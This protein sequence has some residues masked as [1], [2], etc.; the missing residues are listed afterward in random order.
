MRN[1]RFNITV[2]H[3]FSSISAFGAEINSYITTSR[4]NVHETIQINPFNF[5]NFK[6]YNYI[7][8]FF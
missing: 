1:A 7:L 2:P 3:L 4:F 6:K 5:L 8:P